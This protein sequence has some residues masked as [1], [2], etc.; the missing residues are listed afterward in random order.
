[1]RRLNQQE[2]QNLEDARISLA[3]G[4]HDCK[5]FFTGTP[6]SFKKAAENIATIYDRIQQARDRIVNMKEWHCNTS[7][8]LAGLSQVLF[9]EDYGHSKPDSENYHAQDYGE[10]T[11]WPLRHLFDET[12][13]TQEGLLEKMEEFLTSVGYEFEV[14]EVEILEPI[15]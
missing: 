8:C 4:D 7:H 10:Y 9:D 5:H 13:M 1:M 11:I 2:R 15:Q 3:E 14:R 6:V 12:N